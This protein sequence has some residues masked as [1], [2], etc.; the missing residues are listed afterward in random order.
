M[1]FFGRNL[2][3]K[4]ADD[5]RD[6]TRYAMRLLAAKWKD[7]QI[8]EMRKKGILEVKDE[9]LHPAFIP[10]RFP[11]DIGQFQNKS[12]THV[13]AVALPSPTLLAFRKDVIE[14]YGHKVPADF[15]GVYRP[16]V[17]LA[18]GPAGTSLKRDARVPSGA[19][20]AGVLMLKLGT[21]REIY[22]F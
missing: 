14:A 18:E 11:G 20:N 1:V 7:G 9:E 22:T 3:P 21:L 17:S 15:G 4:Q 13:H 10:V 8:A 19:T 2:S 12:A 6:A 16:H 5:A